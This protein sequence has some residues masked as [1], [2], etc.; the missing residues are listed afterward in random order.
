M[1]GYKKKDDVAA[2]CIAL[3]E[4]VQKHLSTYPVL[5]VDGLQSTPTDLEKRLRDFARLRFDVDE[6]RVAYEAALANER[7]QQRAE[8]AL[9]GAVVA[10]VRGSF[11]NAPEVLA[12]FGI[13]PKKTPTPPTVDEKAT[14]VAKREATREARHTM[15]PSKSSRSTATSPASP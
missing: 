15:G 9:T 8:T 7:S 1:S 12:D 2:A 4:G 11:G 5:Y 14:A 6:K 10:L 13:K 3:A